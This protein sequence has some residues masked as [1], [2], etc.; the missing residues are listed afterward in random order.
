MAAPQRGT[1]SPGF[2]AM[3]LN[4]SPLPLLK[5]VKR[6]KKKK[7]KKKKQKKD[8]HRMGPQVSRK[9]LR[10]RKNWV[11]PVVGRGCSNENAPVGFLL[12]G[13]C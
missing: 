6:K 7:K 12:I 9:C 2:L 3:A 8:G 11:G 4:S 5:V 13:D 10:K 1:V